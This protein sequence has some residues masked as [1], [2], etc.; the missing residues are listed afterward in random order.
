MIVVISEDHID[1]EEV[2]KWLDEAYAEGFQNGYD[3]GKLEAKEIYVPYVPAYPTAIPTWYYDRN[4]V[5][6][7]CKGDNNERSYCGSS[8]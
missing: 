1:K 6:Y 3:K 2:K 8:E 5:T 4:Q 7:T